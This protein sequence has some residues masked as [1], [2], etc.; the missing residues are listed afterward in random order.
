M[1]LRNSIVVI[2]LVV[3]VA[4][5]AAAAATPG[6]LSTIGAPASDREVTGWHTDVTPNGDGLPA[7]SGTAAIGAKIFSEKCA[8]CHGAAALG[9]K[10]PGRGAYPRL[11]GGFGT[12]TAKKPIKTVGSY[13]PYATGVFDYIRRAMPLYAPGSLTSDEVYSLT[14][15]ILARNDAIAHGEIIDAASLPKVKMANAKGF[16]PSQESVRATR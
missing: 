5:A 9:M 3:S 14:V 8:A 4:T 11:V 16:F 10:V 13:W 1:S 15:Y 7:G 6:S 2:G 12:L